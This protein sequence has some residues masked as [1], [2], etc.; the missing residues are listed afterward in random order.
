[1]N[2]EILLEEA[3]RDYADNERD[4]RMCELA[5]QGRWNIINNPKG[6]LEECLSMRPNI[7]KTIQ[8]LGG[9]VPADESDQLSKLREE[10]EQ[11]KARYQEEHTE[12]VRLEEKL[13]AAQQRI[14]N[15]EGLLECGS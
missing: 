2:T 7:L 12:R 5:I 6:V 9:T 14:Y 11:L 10:I 1:M 4:I 13:K 15:L 3:L 8:D